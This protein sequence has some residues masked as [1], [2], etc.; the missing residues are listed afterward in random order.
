MTQ[1]WLRCLCRRLSLTQHNKVAHPHPFNMVVQVLYNP[2]EVPYQ[3]LLD[4]FTSI[5]NPTQ[6]NRQVRLS[7]A[8]AAPMD[9]LLLPLLLTQPPAC[10]AH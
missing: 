6:L 9:T 1:A 3:Q 8:K 2:D 4:V 7:Q 10:G 5:H